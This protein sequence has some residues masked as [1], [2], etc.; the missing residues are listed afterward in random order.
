MYIK[1]ENTMEALD[2]PGR[3]LKWLFHPE[4]GEAENCSMN[5][6]EIAAGETV[7]PAHSHPNGEEVIYVIAGFGKVMVSDE[8][9]DLKAGNAVL[10]PKGAVHMVR[11]TGAEPLKLACFF[12][13]RAD[14]DA[15]RYHDEIDFPGQQI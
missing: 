9:R 7:K 15:Y 13:P 12:A 4:Q 1:D 2:V 11:N 3:K 6:V 10:F 8:V 5:V 14:F